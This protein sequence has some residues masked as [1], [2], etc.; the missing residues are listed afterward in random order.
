MM[1]VK[2]GKPSIAPTM[3]VTMALPSMSA[4]IHLTTKSTIDS[5]IDLVTATGEI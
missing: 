3:P 4:T 5:E 2:T 1:M